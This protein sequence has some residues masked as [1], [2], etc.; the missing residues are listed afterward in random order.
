MNLQEILGDAYREG[1][2]IDEINS[3]LNGKRIADLSTGN[4]ID[5]NKYE[6]EVADL[7]KKLAEQKTQLQSK[8][9]DDE[10]LAAKD[11]E[12][13]KLIEDLQKQVKTQTAEINRSKATA[14]FAS[15]KSILDIKDDDEGYTSF[16]DN[17]SNIDSQVSNDVVNYI[18]K[19]IKTA[20]E[21]GK[22]DAVKN[23]LGD[24]G[25][26]HSGSAS[27]SGKN[28]FGKELAQ[29]TQMKTS[30]YDYFKIN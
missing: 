14:G 8:M 9:S 11:K 24:M 21:K 20:Y 27:S 13:A 4:Y 17:M 19:A 23:G 18:S 30:D 2:S 5:K 22:T 16:I 25:K 10:K 26:Q 29:A 1:M 3:A 15:A 7:N 6:R 28:N 12:T